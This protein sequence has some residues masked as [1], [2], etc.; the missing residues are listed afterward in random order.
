VFVSD[1][2]NDRVEKFTSSGVFLTTWG[3]SGS[4]NGQFNIPGHLCL[5]STG[6]VYVADTFNS[7]VQEFTNIGTFLTSF[8]AMGSGNGQFFDPEGLALD[9]SG[10]VYVADTGNGQGTS[11]NRVEVFAPSSGSVGGATMP[12]DK[13]ALLAMYIGPALAAL[14]GT[15]LIIVLVKRRVR[16]TSSPTRASE[17]VKPVGSDGQS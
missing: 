6:N 2:N 5:D 10:N 8:G 17:K 13:L 7:R 9:T 16:E 15:T 14:V 11:N 12:V 1:S 3:T 4:G